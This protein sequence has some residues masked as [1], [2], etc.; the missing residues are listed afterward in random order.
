MGAIQ[1]SQ[2]DSVQ[3]FKI[4]GF[5]FVKDAEILL[6]DAART[7]P[8]AQYTVMAQIAATRKW[9]P[10]T[11]VTA[12]DGSAIP[13]GILLTDGG[14]TA[15]QL[16][17]GDVTGAMIAVGGMGYQVDSSQLVFDAGSTGGGTPLTL[18]TVFTANAV[19]SGTATPYLLIIG[20]RQLNQLGIF[21][22][23]TVALTGAEN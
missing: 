17:A 7:V 10:W 4:G 6:T 22:T 9:V 8:L 11:T 21:P 15:A 19:G 16:A 14:F 13:L 23:S 20:E 2:V 12:T 5:P 3:P 1:S 18:N